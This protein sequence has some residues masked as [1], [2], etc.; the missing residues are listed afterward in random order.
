[1]KITLKLFAML[2]DYLPEEA[3]GQRALE[4]A[5]PEGS[6]VASVVEQFH[7]PEKLVHLT[8]VNGEYVERE[9]RASH[10]LHDGDVLAIWPPVAG[11]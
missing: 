5:L 3:R 10:R 7:L 6:T 1:M 2:Q 8:L 4:L 9:A 11:G